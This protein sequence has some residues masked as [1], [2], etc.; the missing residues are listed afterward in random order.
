MTLTKADIVR[1]VRQ[2]VRFKPRRKSQQRFLFP[3]MDCLFLGRRRA[4]A[5]VDTLFETIKGTLAR[6]E[7]VRISRF[8]KFQVRF[9]WA[10]RG[11]N[12]QTGEMIILKSR[13]IVTFRPSTKLKEKMN[14]PQ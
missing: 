11:R 4:S 9:K 10:R 5:I 2:R 3:E 12:P 6:G 14:S 13:R 8:G 7:D 1:S